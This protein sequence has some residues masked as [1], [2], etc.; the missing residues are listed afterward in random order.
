MTPA[1]R[2]ELVESVVSAYREPDPRGGVRPS[3]AFYDL[4]D[5]G[6][7]EAFERTIAQRAI[8]VALDPEGQSATVKAVLAKIARGG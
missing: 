2:E 7:A 3:P 5:A 1:E 6:R 4:D 8:E